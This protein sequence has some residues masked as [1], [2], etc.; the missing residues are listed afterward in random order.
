M[1]VKFQIGELLG[2]GLTL[3]VLGIGLAYGLTVMS[4]VKVDMCNA[5]PNSSLLHGSLGGCYLCDNSTY[6]T[7]FHN[8]SHGPSCG[9]DTWGAA[10][11]SNHTA[12]QAGGAEFNASGSAIEGIAKIPEKIPTIATVI[13]ASVI[14]SILVT[15]LWGKFQ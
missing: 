15:Y 4:D 13:V 14:I 1:R 5:G 2:I 8:A 12:T 10:N 9:N 6:N 11:N 7:F 3:I